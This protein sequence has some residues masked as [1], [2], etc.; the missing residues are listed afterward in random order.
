MPG[1]R[2]CLGLV[3]RWIGVDVGGARKGFDVAVVDERQVLTLRGR[4]N[5]QQIADL[6]MTCR[7]AVVAIDCPC[8]CAPEGHSWRAGERQLARQVCG[9]RWTPD[10]EH[11]CGSP[12]YAWMLEGLALFGALADYDAEVIEVFPTASPGGC[13]NPRNQ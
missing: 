13:T 1:S 4:L 12:Y 3:A 9:I 2:A 11:V 7:P 6:V 8:S 5:C 10:L